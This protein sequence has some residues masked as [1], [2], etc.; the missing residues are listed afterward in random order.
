MTQ[1]TKD[2][3][4]FR[5]QRKVSFT[6]SKFLGSRRTSL[7]PPPVGITIWTSPHFACHLSWPVEFS[8]LWV[9]GRPQ[10]WKEMRGREGE[11]GDQEDGT[12]QGLVY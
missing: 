3:S 4:L 5:E 1:L 11:A 7:E 2:F 9:R 10:T 6:T 12:Y 8:Y